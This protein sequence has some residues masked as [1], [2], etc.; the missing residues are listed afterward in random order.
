MMGATVSS[1]FRYIAS[2]CLVAMALVVP[3]AAAAPDFQQWLGDLKA[4]AL[5]EGLRPATV[6][7]ALTGIAP[8]PRI[9]ELDGKQPER[10]VTFDTYLSRT[11][12]KARIKKARERMVTHKAL[13]T[14]MS[15]KYGVPARFIVALW[16]MET[17]FG[18]NMGGFKV[19]DALA[20]LAYDGR[21]SAFFRGE[22]L[23]ALRIL[24]EGHIAPDRMLGSWAGAMGQCQFMPSSFF[25]FAQDGDGDGKRD[26]WT[27]HADVFASTANYLAT[28]G[29]KTDQTWGRAVRLPKGADSAAWSGMDKQ[30]QPLSAWARRGLRSA[31]GKPLPKANMEAWLV[32]PDGPKG[33]AFLVYGNYR[34]IMD[35]NRSTYF[36]TAVGILADHIGSGK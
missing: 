10:T 9:L 4:E 25:K 22:L 23:K 26:I 28:V 2:V 20:T 12:T 21:R 36:A 6:D 5:R 31:D 7:L 35:W 14:Q 24:D 29:W 15:K 8:I 13:L 3:G 19:V 30:A 17:D 1:R 27:T 18:G 16:G 32:Q 11:V 33:K 34:T